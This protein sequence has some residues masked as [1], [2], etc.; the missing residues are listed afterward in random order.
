MKKLN[1]YFKIIIL[2]CA[3]LISS[4]NIYSQW[5]IAGDLSGVAGSRP[6]VSVVDGNTAYV[7]GGSDINATYKTTNGGTDWIQLNT[8][9]FHTFYAIFAKDAANVFAGDNGGGGAVRFYKS[10]NGGSTWTIIDSIPV[11]GA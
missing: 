11:A 5:I 4:K 1:L 3:I 9:T 2:I 10:I 8:G 7:T 6:Q